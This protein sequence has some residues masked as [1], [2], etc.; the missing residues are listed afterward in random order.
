MTGQEAMKDDLDILIELSRHF[1]GDLDAVQAGGG[2]TSVK[3][4]DGNMYVKASGTTLRDADR[5][6]FL[7]VSPLKSLTILAD[8]SLLPM[9]RDARDRLVAKKMAEAAL[10]AASGRRPSIET[11][12]HAVLGK[13]VLHV[14]PVYVNALTCLRGGACLAAELF[15]RALKYAWV[16]YATPGYSLGIETKKVVDEFE[17]I[18]GVKPEIVFLQNHGIVISAADKDAIFRHYDRITGVLS[19]YFGRLDHGDGPE[20]PPDGAAL[21][22]L[23]D[24]LHDAGLPGRKVKLATSPVISAVVKDCGA[25]QRLLAARPLYPDQI[26]YCGATPL[27]LDA[28]PSQKKLTA[29]VEDFVSRTGHLPRM[30]VFAGNCVALI[31]ES[32]KELTAI[33]ETLEAHLKVLLLLSRKGDPLYLDAEEV[34]Y[35]TN[36]E[37]EKYRRSQM[38]GQTSG[39]TP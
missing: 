10:D 2:N 37:S 36:W 38:Q 20:R 31:G 24:V 21:S 26:V 29:E 9:S 13:Y 19:R 30:I 27:C 22:T 6:G 14:H 5:S 18:H 35:I 34:T 7:L 28:N 12:L 15:G 39:D 32:E 3:T 8:S 11:F 25:A 23:A 4:A 1:G 17:S 16:P 33:E